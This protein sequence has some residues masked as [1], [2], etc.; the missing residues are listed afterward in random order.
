MNLTPSL[1]TNDMKSCDIISTSRNLSLSSRNRR[2]S[3]CDFRSFS[4]N[5]SPS[6]RT[7]SP[8]SRDVRRIVDEDGL[9]HSFNNLAI[10]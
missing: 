8:S 10:H 2:A 9:F 3:L 4:R 1:P 6:S 5:R 7:I